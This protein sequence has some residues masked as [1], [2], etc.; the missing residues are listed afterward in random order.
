MAN[1]DESLS[2][3]LSYILRHRPDEIG[4]QLDGQ[5]WAAVA[6]LLAKSAAHGRSIDFGA[7]VNVVENSAKKRLF[8]SDDRTRIRALQGHSI[9][10]ELGLQPVRP[11]A[12]LY[13]GTALKFLDSILQTGLA[14]QARHHVHLSSTVDSAWIVGRR[15]GKAA[16]LQIQ[17]ERMHRDGFAFMRTENDVW[18]TDA[19][20]ATYLKLLAQD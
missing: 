11:P 13:H 5:G 9:S 6:E 16:I 15:R 12:L 19:V 3:Y 8:L 10:I 17:A 4:L 20:P 2:K 1:T 14:K 18:L 7:M